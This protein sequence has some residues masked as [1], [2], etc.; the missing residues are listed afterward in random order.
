MIDFIL[1]VIIPFKFCFKKLCAC[2]DDT[3]MRMYSLEKQSNFIMYS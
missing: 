3:R 1:D 2:L